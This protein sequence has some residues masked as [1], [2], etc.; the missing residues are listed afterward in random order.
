MRII[1][2]VIIASLFFQCKDKSEVKT[3]ASEV[4]EEFSIPIEKSK[5]EEIKRDTF[6]DGF[7]DALIVEDRSILNSYIRFPITVRGSLDTDL[8]K[9]VFEEE[10][11]KKFLLSFLNEKSVCGANTMN[12]R[13]RFISKDCIKK[14]R[15]GSEYFIVD[16]FEFKKSDNLWVLNT[17]YSEFYN[18]PE[19]LQ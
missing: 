18:N 6:M 7:L 4:V 8:R 12:N 17:I 15:S 1:Y 11:Y 13:D 10:F 3:T 9:R 2:F 16:K 19:N 14:N 5:K